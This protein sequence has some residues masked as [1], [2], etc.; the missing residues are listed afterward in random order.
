VNDTDTKDNL[1][2]IK[3]GIEEV[4]ARVSASKWLDPVT[5]LYLPAVAFADLGVRSALQEDRRQLAST[6]QEYLDLFALAES[7]NVDRSTAYELKQHQ[8]EYENLATRLRLQGFDVP[9]EDTPAPAVIRFGRVAVRD[10]F[11]T[12]DDCSVLVTV[13]KRNGLTEAFGFFASVNPVYLKDANGATTGLRQFTVEPVL[14]VEQIPNTPDVDNW[15]TNEPEHSAALK[16]ARPVPPPTISVEAP[17]HEERRELARKSPHYKAAEEQ[18]SH[19][20]VTLEML[21][22]KMVRAALC[23]SALAAASATRRNL[24]AF[25]GRDP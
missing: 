3:R 17:T 22:E 10:A 6:A 16:C 23:G 18:F 19:F 15:R 24:F 1:R 13:E 8:V 20:R 5:V 21:N 2:D 25:F 4:V 9:V 14:R 11:L 7:P 12:Y